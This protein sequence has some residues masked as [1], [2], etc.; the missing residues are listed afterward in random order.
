MASATST[1]AAALAVAVACSL[2]AVAPAARARRGSPTPDLD[3]ERDK[4]IDRI[5]RGEDVERATALFAEL[6]AERDNL[7]AP[8]DPMGSTIL[9]TPGVAASTPAAPPQAAAAVAPR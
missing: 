7:I 1:R 6:L 8:R 4:L 9:T 3:A 2:L 5:A